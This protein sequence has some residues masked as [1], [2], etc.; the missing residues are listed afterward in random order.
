[1]KM[2]TCGPTVYDY[3]HIGNFAR[4]V[5]KYFAAF[6]KLRGFQLTH[7]MNLTDVGRPHHRN[8]AAAKIRYP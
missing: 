2:Y 8:A 7:G 4:S 5:F 1:M 3:S 6:L